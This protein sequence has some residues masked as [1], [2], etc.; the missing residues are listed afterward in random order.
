M[1]IGYSVPTLLNDIIK[2]AQE[3]ASEARRVEYYSHCQQNAEQ[4]A[5]IENCVLNIEQALENI[6]ENLQYLK[7][8]EM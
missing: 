3:I 1:E 4:I 2:Q 6:K 7:D 8:E 5:D